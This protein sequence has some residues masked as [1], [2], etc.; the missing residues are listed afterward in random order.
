VRLFLGA[1]VPYAIG[2]ALCTP[3]LASLIS[4]AATPE[5][6]GTVQGAASALESL[7]RTIGPVWGTA[8]L[9]RLGDA[10][11]FGTGAILLIVTIVL[12]LA[13][14]VRDGRASSRA[15]A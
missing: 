1:L 14:P 8:V 5:E 2:S 3:S 11:A 6:Q 4:R 9:Q 7:G 13:G 12:L 10:A 15:A